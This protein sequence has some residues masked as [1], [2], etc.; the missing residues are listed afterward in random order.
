MC[1]EVIIT[2]MIIPT[3]LEVNIAEHLQPTS[4]HVTSYR[5]FANCF[6]YS[7]LVDLQNYL[8]FASALCKFILIR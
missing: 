7:L 2:F 4:C 6:L 5:V 8:T 3:K 1:T